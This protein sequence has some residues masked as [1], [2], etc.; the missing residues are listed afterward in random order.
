[1]DVEG[2]EA[3]RER[4]QLFIRHQSAALA[5]ARCEPIVRAERPR[6]Q[7][8]DADEVD[9]RGHQHPTRVD[10]TAVE[11][12]PAVQRAEAVGPSLPTGGH[13]LDD[14][15]RGDGQREGSE[16]DQTEGGEEHAAP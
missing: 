5:R 13:G 1:M 10:V 12:Q 7:A 2:L 3:R 6:E 16:D 8:A 14:H 11:E 9:R 4:L 15:V